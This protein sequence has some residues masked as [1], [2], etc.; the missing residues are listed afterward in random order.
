MKGVICDMKKLLSIYHCTFIIGAA[1]MLAACE[2]ETSGNGDLDGLWQLTQQDSVGTQTS[3]DMCQSGIFW[4]VQVRL[5]QIK[6][7]PQKGY[8]RFNRSNGRLRLYSAD[9][10]KEGNADTTSLYNYRVLKL[11]G[12]KMVLEDDNV[13]LSFRKY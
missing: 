9:L 10:D 1:L 7:G 5:L 8:Y 4:A 11:N 6:S 13:K 2:F 3:Q 12:S